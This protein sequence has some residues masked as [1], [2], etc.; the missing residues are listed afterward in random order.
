MKNYTKKLILI[1]SFF[2]FCIGTSMVT[3]AEENYF[4]TNP[5]DF[6]LGNIHYNSNYVKD[7]LFSAYFKDINGKNGY[8]AF[9]QI[10]LATESW[11]S[12]YNNPTV[13][14]SQNGWSTNVYDTNNFSLKTSKPFAYIGK[15]YRIA[16]W[17]GSKWLFSEDHIISGS[18]ITEYFED[19]SDF[20]LNPYE[21][22]SYG[23]ATMQR[24]YWVGGNKTMNDFY[25]ISN[26]G[27]IY[28]FTEEIYENGVWNVL[29]TTTKKIGNDVL[30]EIR[31][32]EN[33]SR[34]WN[35]SD[36]GKPIRVTVHCYGTTQ[37]TT[38]VFNENLNVKPYVITYYGNGGTPG[39][40]VQ[41][42]N[43]DSII[44]ENIPKIKRVGFLLDG[45]Y[46]SDGTNVNN[47]KVNKKNVKVYAHWS[48]CTDHFDAD[49]DGFCDICGLGVTH[50]IF[51][52]DGGLINGSSKYEVDWAV[53]TTHVLPIPEKNGYLFIGW[54]GWN[55]TVP[56]T[57]TTCKAMWKV[58][59]VKVGL[60]FNKPTA[61]DLTPLCTKTLITAE[62]LQKYD[63]KESLPVP[64]LI[65]WR[66]DGWYTDPSA[67][68]LITNDSS[69]LVDENHTLYAHWTAVP[70]VITSQP[71]NFDL[72]EF[73][74]LSESNYFDKYGPLKYPYG[75]MSL[76]VTAS[77]ESTTKYLWYESKD[78]VS[79]S[80][81][82][83][84]DTILTFSDKTK[85]SI[86][87]SKAGNNDS[88]F[89]IYD[90]N[91]NHNNYQY[92]CIVKNNAGSVSTRPIK[93]TVFWLPNIV[94]K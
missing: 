59:T 47:V 44:G 70:P 11:P 81:I 27:D 52:I 45:W 9:I 90:V 85:Y 73:I 91:R 24:N 60:D 8:N 89:S 74:D 84:S 56:E 76:R 62:Y 3:F 1:I 92:K 63:Y 64:T 22:G 78:G 79:W 7:D 61:S 29:S 75:N 40:T 72:I 35:L 68:T 23:S 38:H 18:I 54:S 57:T 71:N 33:G 10:K 94:K 88:I 83:D 19:Q 28:I 13:D 25:I 43:Y 20:N 5:K 53:G 15:V 4:V 87:V 12:E 48:E 50:L 93:M 55:G 77:G 21:I 17:T 69:V 34:I 31:F 16:I 37:D 82:S 65:D 41:N 49:A 32:G 30:A 6:D 39:E 51:D 26:I 80:Y 66:F 58:A 2:C 36:I 42:I 14:N 86:E 46:D 67:G